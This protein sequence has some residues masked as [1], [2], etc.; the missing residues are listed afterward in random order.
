MVFHAYSWS[1]F[2]GNYFKA[3]KPFLCN[4]N[5]LL[6]LVEHESLLCLLYVVP[7]ILVE[8]ESL[9]TAILEQLI[10]FFNKFSIVL[11]VLVRFLSVDSDIF[12]GNAF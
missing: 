2:P 3:G 7:L 10:M 8:D 12:V 4:L 6:F 5:L 1:L 9:A 11:L